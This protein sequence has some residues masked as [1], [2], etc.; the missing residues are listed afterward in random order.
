MKLNNK[1]LIRT[2]TFLTN[3]NVLSKNNCV[4]LLFGLRKSKNTVNIPE[5]MSLNKYI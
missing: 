1:A 2:S 5:I 4:K 3:K